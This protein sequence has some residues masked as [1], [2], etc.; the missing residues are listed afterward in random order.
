MTLLFGILFVFQ[1]LPQANA[2]VKR[3]K[4]DWYLPEVLRKKYKAKE[5][6]E[7]MTNPAKLLNVKIKIPGIFKGEKANISALNANVLAPK[8]YYHFEVSTVGG[9]SI[10]IIIHRMRYRKLIKL[11]KGVQG[12][13]SVD[14]YGTIRKLRRPGNAALSKE[15]GAG[16]RYYLSLEEVDFVKRKLPASEEANAAPAD[17]TLKLE[18]TRFHPTDLLKKEITFHCALNTALQ[19]PGNLIRIETF[20]PGKLGQLW[21]VI[22][23]IDLNSIDVINSVEPGQP[24]KVVG[25]V[26]S[27]KVGKEKVYYMIAKIAAGDKKFLSNFD[28]KELKKPFGERKPQ[29]NK[30]TAGDAKIAKAI[31]KIIAKGNEIFAS[32]PEGGEG[33]GE[34]KNKL[35]REELMKRLSKTPQ[36]ERPQP[37][38]LNFASIKSQLQTYVQAYQTDEEKAREK[39]RIN[40]LSLQKKTLAGM[41]GHNPV[42]TNKVKTTRSTK[43]CDSV[44]GNINEI[45]LRRRQKIIKKLKWEEIAPEQFVDFFEYYLKIRVKYMSTGATKEEKASFKFEAANGAYELA[46]LADWF[47]LTD[48]AKRF[49][50]QAIRIDP[51]FKS[52]IEVMIPYAVQ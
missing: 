35:P 37:Q 38:G 1:S 20:W 10:P 29:K 12:S 11:F 44:W 8:F 15:Y 14:Y 36:Q 16:F 46:L 48:K 28:K 17:G 30:P 2:Q 21:I 25:E 5:Y 9:K 43:S 13:V 45:V 32:V 6:S 51:S 42:R 50:L 24:L 33:E 4:K 39:K 27:I 47:T 19:M 41:I 31:S 40:L 7:A 18:P 26:K 52:K 23:N 3:S 49:A 22:T 34:T